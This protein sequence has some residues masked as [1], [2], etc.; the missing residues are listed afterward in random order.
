MITIAALVLLPQFAVAK[1]VQGGR[2]YIERQREID[3][4]KKQLGVEEQELRDFEKLVKQV[5]AL[6]LPEEA[7]AL[8]KLSHKIR[9]V[10]NDVHKQSLKRLAQVQASDAHASTSSPS[11]RPKKVA[12]QRAGTSSVPDGESDLDEP[13]RSMTRRVDR[14]GAIIREVQGLDH[15]I[16]NGETDVAPRYRHL[17]GEFVELMRDANTEIATAIERDEKDLVEG[18][19]N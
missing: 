7:K 3:Q 16:A 8:Q 11:A 5:D 2:A 18:R 15:W 10:L 4:R 13:L 17:L 1:G 14:M 12:T 19:W 9:G 6:Q